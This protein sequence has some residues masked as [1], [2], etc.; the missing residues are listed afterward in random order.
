M[1][2][3]WL[4]GEWRKLYYEIHNNKPKCE[5]LYPDEIVKIRE[6]LLYAQV[7]LG[8]VEANQ[9]AEFHQEL[10]NRIMKYYFDLLQCQKN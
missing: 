5:G 10:Y 2:K 6:W 9:N 1:K 3:E 8:Y 7:E 4:K